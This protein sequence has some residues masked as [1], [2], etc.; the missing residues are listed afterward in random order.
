MSILSFGLSVA[1]AHL[2]GFA[3]H[4]LSDKSREPIAVGGVGVQKFVD[5]TAV[6][7]F[8]SLADGYVISFSVRLWLN[9]LLRVFRIAISSVEPLNSSP[10]GRMPEA[11]IAC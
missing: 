5:R 4:D 7:V 6:V 9:C 11:S 2:E 8:P 1:A 3:D 10:L